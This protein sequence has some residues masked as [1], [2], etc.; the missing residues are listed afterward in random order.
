MREELLN[1]YERELTFI[2]QVGAEFAQKYPKI[3]SRLLLERDRC[4]DPHVERMLEGFALLAARVHLK[5]DDDFPE[6]TTALL[7]TLYPH[8]LRPIP[9][10]S[11]VEFSVK[12]EQGKLIAGLPIPRHSMLRSREVDGVPCKFSTCYDTRL[13]PVSVVEASWRTPD[14]IQ[15]PVRISEAVGVIRVVLQCSPDMTFD[16]FDMRTLRF[17]LNG[18]GNLQHTLYELLCNNCVRIMVREVDAKPGKATISFSP[19]ALR[20]LGFAENESMLPYVRRSFAGYRLLQEYFAF[21]E[22]FFFFDLEGLD[23]LSKGGPKDKVEI[24]FFISRFE[25]N[26]R[27][28]LLEMGLT[29]STFRLGCTPV[30]NLFANTSEPILMDELQF[31]YP[32]VPAGRRAVTEIFSVDEVLSTRSQTREIVPFEPFYSKRHTMAFEKKK[33]YW[34]STRRSSGFRDDERTDVYLC[35]V[36]LTGAPILP[37]SD[38]VTVHCTCTNFDLPSRLPFGN[39]NGDFELEGVS[40]VRQAICLRK[41]TTSPRPPM[42]R[43][44]LWRLVSHLSLNYLSLVEDGREALQ[45]ILQLYNVGNSIYLQNQIAGIVKIS[46]QRHF[47]RLISENGVT[48]ARGTRV[49]M[50]L[51]EEQ[52]VGG[53]VF[54]FGSVLEHFL[55][56]YV[57]MNS[58][59]QLAL[60][61]QQRKEV[62]REWLPRAGQQILI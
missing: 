39:A 12:P 9:S 37:D 48:S 43:D 14:R 2:R 41:P 26:E 56:M 60:S 22:K 61:T 16:K 52:F 8:Y 51:D 18:E 59:T 23:P 10:M 7:G 30:I 58:F 33:A 40:A 35:L 53:G 4:E 32:I 11:V 55:G 1:Y 6:I 34:H 28:Q 50:L 46:S 20:P 19:S 44:A 42:G 3:A 62:L 38:A 27:T 24:L 13:W 17:Y 45:Q 21:P 5:V 49:D 54:L 31:E 36:D 25:R 29:K 15:P 47:A 57:S